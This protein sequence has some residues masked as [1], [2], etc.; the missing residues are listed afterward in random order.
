MDIK[1]MLPSQSGESCRG[2]HNSWFKFRSYRVPG[3]PMVPYT[4]IVII[5]LFGSTGLLKK[6]P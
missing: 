3:I 5:L 1:E 6:W 2:G 4:K